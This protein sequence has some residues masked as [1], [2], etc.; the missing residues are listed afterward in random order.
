MKKISTKEKILSES[1]KLFAKEGFA[2]TSVRD[3]AKA[4]GIQA[5]ALYNHFKGKDQ[6]L[7]SLVASLMESAIVTIFEDKDPQEL[8]KRGKSLLS[9]IATTFKLLSF[10]SKNE[11]LFKLLMQEIYKNSAIRDLYLEYFYQQ[12]IKKLSSALFMM[13]QEEKIISSDPLMLANEF[14]SPLFFYQSQVALLKIDGRSTSSAVTLFE[15]HVD[16]FWGSIRIDKHQ[17]ETLF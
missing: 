17:Q 14:L 2:D 11:A 9:N 4:V 15:K 10:D 5:G 12:N 7:E 6:I 3:I 1:L 8:S 13:M 16:F